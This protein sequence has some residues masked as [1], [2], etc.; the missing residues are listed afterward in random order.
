MQEEGMSEF[1]ADLTRDLD[2][3]EDLLRDPAGNAPE[4]VGNV[5]Q[6]ELLMLS[7]FNWE[8]NRTIREAMP[9]WLR[10]RVDSVLSRARAAIKS[11]G[12]GNL[13]AL[14]DQQIADWLAERKRRHGR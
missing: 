11:V 13:L 12:A 8:P 1:I 14:A 10:P 6:V 4:L 2:T 3:I 5:Q 7:H 9:A